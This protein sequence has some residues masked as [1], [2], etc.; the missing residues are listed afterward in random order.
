MATPLSEIV[1]H[2]LPRLLVAGVDYND[3]RLVLSRVE[4]LRDWC[5]QWKRLAA[6]H[7]ELGETAL[8][9]GHTVTAADA[10]RRASLY[11]HV[12]QFVFFDDAEE[13]YAVQQLQQAAYRKGMAYYR[14]PTEQLA[15]HFEDVTFGG[16]LR[17]PAR[18]G[19][20]RLRGE[21]G[22]PT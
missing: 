12:A 5:P 7:Q 6:V 2:R 13:K 8:A 17:L 3:V 1:E 14:P 18:G 21:G 19:K 22:L 15:V 16:N 20:S 10:L 11:Y 9:E 4:T